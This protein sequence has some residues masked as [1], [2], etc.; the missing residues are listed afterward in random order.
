MI[1]Y[2]YYVYIYYIIYILYYIYIYIYILYVLYIYI[3]ISSITCH[4]HIDCDNCHTHVLI[5]EPK[6]FASVR[7]RGAASSA[8][9]HN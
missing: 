5:K 7:C 4:N 8:M 2:I 9:Y 1:Y 3:C 6:D